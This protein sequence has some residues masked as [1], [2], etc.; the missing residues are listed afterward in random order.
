MMDRPRDQPANNQPTNGPTNQQ[1]DIPSY[2]DA[3]SKKQ[4]EWL[5]NLLTGYL[6]YIFATQGKRV[7]DLCALKP[8]LH[9]S[10]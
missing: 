9:L 2:R 3:A 1:A 6:I 8:T 5:T 7:Y 4:E 10:Y